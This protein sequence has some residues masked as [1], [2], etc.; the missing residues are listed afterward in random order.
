M[1]STPRV[2]TNEIYD[3]AW[4]PDG[5]HFIVGSTDNTARIYNAHT[6]TLI[7]IIADHSHYV[8]GVA[9][10]P[11]NEFIA[12]QSSDRT[13]HIHRIV[14]NK[15][16]L[17]FQPH[18][19]SQKMDIHHSRT[20]SSS[21]STSTRPAIVR[22]QSTTNSDSESVFTSAASDQ[23]GDDTTAAAVAGPSSSHGGTSTS[24]GPLT[25]SASQPGT[26]SMAMQPPS[27]RSSF[28]SSVAASPPPIGPS[29]VARSPSPLPAIRPAPGPSS[30]PR[31]VKSTHLFGDESYT[32]YFRRLTFSPD[33][34]LL[35]TPAGQIDDPHLTFLQ[36]T[37]LS[38]DDP[39]PSTAAAKPKKPVDNGPKPTVYIYSRANLSTAPIAH[40]PGQ[41]TAS[42]AVKFSPIFYELRDLA[43]VPHG[44]I[45]HP[46]TI[47]EK[48][49]Q[50]IK[51]SLV[52]GNTMSSSASSSSMMTMVAA[53]AAVAEGSSLASSAVAE[54]SRTPSKRAL[55]P[56]PSIEMVEGSGMLLSPSRTTTASSPAPASVFA[57]PYRM[58]FAGA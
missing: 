58:F 50:E 35:V 25:P 21:S 23:G 4:S 49:G 36:P 15:G 37:P 40:L 45:P 53:E 55:S 22:R 28:S 16:I 43:C 30:A 10:D 56:S 2:T 39:S 1:T 7:K 32:H 44:V 3:L 47:D 17:E 48:N 29:R 26:P 18:S 57:L 6:G 24:V 20:P 54:M 46:V 5:T 41:K 19:R 14:H 33:G 8:Q 31:L 9:W 27:R 52:G 42:V 34:A 12:T 11:L 51:V 13:V 38:L